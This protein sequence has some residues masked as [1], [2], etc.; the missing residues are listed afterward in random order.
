MLAE[1]LNTRHVKRQRT[2]H[3]V[4]AVLWLFQ[5]GKKLGKSVAA[6]KIL[7]IPLTALGQGIGLTQLRLG[8]SNLH[9]GQFLGSNG[10]AAVSPVNV[11]QHDLHRSAVNDDVMVIQK[12]VIL[13]FV[14]QHIYVEQAAAVYVEGFYE[15]FL[16]LFDLL[17]L[18]DVER[19]GLVVHV[20]RL[21]GFAVIVQSDAGEQRGVG[22]KGCFYSVKQSLAVQ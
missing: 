2:C 17:Y 3:V 15:T 9:E 21:Y 11:L 6:V 22:L 12:Q 13:V 1:G 16:H 18:L 19:P 7:G 10:F 14:V 8:L 4:L 20:K 5:V